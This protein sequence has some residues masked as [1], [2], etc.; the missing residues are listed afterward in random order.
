MRPEA[1]KNIAYSVKQNGHAVK[2]IDIASL[3]FIFLYIDMFC[4]LFF[5]VTVLSTHQRLLDFFAN[6]DKVLPRITRVFLDTSSYEYMTACIFAGL[7]LVIKERNDNK[8]M[9]MAL[10]IFSLFLIWSFVFF[11]IW[12]ISLP[13]KG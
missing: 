1:F 5:S 9:T 13:F 3:S 12:G 7:L 11:Y 8:K 6:T 2:S 4:L 10:N